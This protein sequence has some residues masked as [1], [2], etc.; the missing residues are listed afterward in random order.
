MTLREVEQTDTPAQTFRAGLF[1]RTAMNLVLDARPPT[2]GAMVAALQFGQ[3][4]LNHWGA[5]V[6]DALLKLDGNEAYVGDQLIWLWKRAA[7]SL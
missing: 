2:R 1:K 7:I 6:Q 3:F 4:Y 5:S